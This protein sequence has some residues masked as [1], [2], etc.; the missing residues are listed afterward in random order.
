MKRVVSWA[1]VGLVLAVNVPPARATEWKKITENAVKDSFF[2]DVSSIQRQGPFVTYWEYRD[3]PEPNN[4]FLENSVDQPVY[5]AVIRWSADCNAK[6][7][8]LRRVNAFT[9]DRKLIQRFDYGETGTLM[10]PRVGSSGYQVL[11]YACSAQPSATPS[12]EDAP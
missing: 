7:Q 3:F 10:Q 9:K 1:I 6:V 4:A 11:N 8:R 2:I 5:G 12:S